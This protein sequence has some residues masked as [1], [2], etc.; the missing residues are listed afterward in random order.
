VGFPS[1]TLAGD[2]DREE[3]MNMKTIF[4]MGIAVLIFI[5][6]CAP[7][8]YLKE[9]KLGDRKY[10]IEVFDYYRDVPGIFHK[11]ARSICND[12]DFT[13]L[14]TQS[15]ELGFSLLVAEIECPKDGTWYHPLASQTGFKK[16]T[17]ECRKDATMISGINDAKF[18]INPI[19][20]AIYATKSYK[21]EFRS[22]ME[23]RGYMWVEK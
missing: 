21:L 5:F 13:S 10:H 14:N 4:L 12:Y 6:G 16:D 7:D 17:Y 18:S 22:C 19:M 23:A 11:R 15:K 9:T 1:V 8:P 20:S 3:D 2:L